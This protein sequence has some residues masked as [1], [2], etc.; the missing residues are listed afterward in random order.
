M[1]KD[2]PVQ[3]KELL[4]KPNN[5]CSNVQAAI[6]EITQKW[7]TAQALSL[8]DWVYNEENEI[9]LWGRT[10]TDCHWC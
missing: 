1:V 9:G 8:G 4:D 7:C 10:A 2:F 5:Y 6:S 3:V